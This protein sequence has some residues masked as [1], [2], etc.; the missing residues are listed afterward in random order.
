MIGCRFTSES[1]DVGALLGGIMCTMPSVLPIDEF[2]AARTGLAIRM[3]GFEGDR[4][5]T[6]DCGGLR[7]MFASALWSGF[8]AALGAGG[9]GA[10]LMIGVDGL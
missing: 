3:F 8:R 7:T 2:M 6:V 9:M 10:W 4:F 5:T 1:V